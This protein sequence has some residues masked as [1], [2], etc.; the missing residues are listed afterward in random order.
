MLQQWVMPVMQEPETV[1]QPGE[2][3]QLLPVVFDEE[4][5]AHFYELA[6]QL[7]ASFVREI[8]Q[9]FLDTAPASIAAVRQA[10]SAAD[11]RG[12]MET[13]HALKGS[14]GNLA[15]R[16]MAAIA[17]E[18]ESL[19]RGQSVTGSGPLIDQLEQEFDRT[20]V[21]IETRLQPA[22]ACLA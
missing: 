4:A 22:F 7:D 18:L 10:A 12:L 17:Q 14:C 15:I 19:G 9:I 16:R 2:D 13:A 11:A 5:M 3:R 21:E 1:N 20:R 6:D 8:L